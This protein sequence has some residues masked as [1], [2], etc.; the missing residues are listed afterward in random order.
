MCDMIGIR[1]NSG[2][3]KRASIIECGVTLRG[4]TQGRTVIDARREAFSANLRQSLGL[5]SKNT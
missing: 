4:D 1:G 5:L 3:T 2:A